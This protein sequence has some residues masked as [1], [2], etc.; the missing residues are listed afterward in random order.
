MC[1]QRHPKP[2]SPLRNL[3]ETDGI[4][5]AAGGR[6]GRRV[7]PLPVLPRPFRCPARVTSGL[8]EAQRRS[9]APYSPAPRRCRCKWKALAG[10]GPL[11]WGRNSAS[12]EMGGVDR[13][14]W[15]SPKSHNDSL[16]PPTPGA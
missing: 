14:G 2:G 1:A 7:A 15:G 16:C 6:P 11:L 13:L 5:P 9:A 8:P 4:V 12:G 3:G 10:R